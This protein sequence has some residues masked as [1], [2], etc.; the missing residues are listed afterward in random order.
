MSVRA[1]YA[2]AE[3]AILRE[4]ARRAALRPVGQVATA[5]ELAAMRRFASRL[6]ARQRAAVYREVRRAVTGVRQADLLQRLTAAERTAAAQAGLLLREGRH[7]PRALAGLID[8]AGRRWSLSGYADVATVAAVQR[9]AL[10]RQLRDLRRNGVTHV[11]VRAEPGECAKCQPWDRRVLTL[12][13]LD[14]AIRAG[15]RHIR[16][17]CSITRAPSTAA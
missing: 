1:L 3:A 15:L 13:E 2:S 4:V 9:Q 10:D 14:R 17:R 6:F 16:C 7:D 12:R 8:R 5:A 11:F